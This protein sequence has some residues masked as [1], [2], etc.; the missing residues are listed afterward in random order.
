VLANGRAAWES[1]QLL[2][3]AQPDWIGSIR[4]SFSYKGFS[5]NFLVD[6]KMGGD[7][8]SGT[9]AK[10][11]NHGVHAGTLEGREEW[12]L[13]TLILGENNNERQGR[14]LFG[15]NYADS[16]R[17]KGRIY[18]NSALGVQDADGNWAAERDAN[19][20]IIYT[21]RWL[22]PQVYGF[23]GLQ[24]QRRFVYDASYVKLREVT[25]GY[26]IPHRLIKKIKIKNA[27]ISVVGRNLW[28]IYRNTPQGI[29]PESGTTSGNGQG[30]EYG[31]FLP[32]RTIGVNVKLVF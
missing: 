25:F 27:K 24:D 6:I 20:E 16:D 26:N 15:N 18:E 7:L 19:G 23:D 1:N 31:S 29:D 10:T 32:T 8:Y 21:Q 14:G 11:Y 17:P 5:L 12:L 28:T 4:N 9:M 3:N 2:G 13:S 22:N 30:I